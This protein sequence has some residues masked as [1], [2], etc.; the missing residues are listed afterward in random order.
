M[1]A[2]AILSYLRARDAGFLSAADAAAYGRKARLAADW[3]LDHV[4]PQS[5]D[6][7]GYFPVTGQSEPRPPEN[8]AWQLGW[9]LEA[10]TRLHEIEKG[11]G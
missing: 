10:L 8:L 6:A 9:T 5:I 2:G 3:L 11:R 4:T 7:G 1:T